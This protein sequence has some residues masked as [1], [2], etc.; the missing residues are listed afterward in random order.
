MIEFNGKIKI[1]SADNVKITQSEITNID[2]NSN[3]N[4]FVSVN[5]NTNTSYFLVDDSPSTLSLSENEND[6]YYYEGTEIC[7]ENKK[8]RNPYL[9]SVYTNKLISQFSIKFDT[10]A[11]HFP[12]SI[13]WR[14]SQ[15]GKEIYGSLTESDKNPNG[16]YI[17]QKTLVYDYEIENVEITYGEGQVTWEGNQ[18]LYTETHTSLPSTGSL[19][20]RG[21][22]LITFKYNELSDNDSVYLILFDTPMNAFDILIDNWNVPYY[23]LKIQGLSVEI[24]IDINRHN[25]ISFEREIADRSDFKLPSWGIISNVGNITFKDK[26]DEVGDYAEKLLLKSD[27][28]V[29]LIVKNTLYKEAVENIGTFYTQDWDYNNNNLEV[30]VSLK[31]DLEEWQ[32]IQTK[33]IPYD[34]LNILKITEESSMKDIYIWLHSKTPSKYQMMS[35]DELNVETQTI[36]ENHKIQYPFLSQSSLWQQWDKLCKAC[37]LYIYKNKGRTICSYSLGS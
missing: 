12:Q 16:V 26:N 32:D 15:Q 34:P 11:N 8:F 25:L 1:L 18:L 37:A 22:L 27:L 31:D 33:G 17:F 28:E 23:P 21:S 2:E 30:S 6:I 10:Y 20:I 24:N 35:F 13:K 7:D 5:N 3:I 14:A 19:S 9:I 36:L 29:D 4:A